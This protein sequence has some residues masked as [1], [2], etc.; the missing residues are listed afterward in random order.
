MAVR[1][2]PLSCSHWRC[3][4]RSAFDTEHV[5]AAKTPGPNTHM[6]SL[7]QLLCLKRNK[8][9]QTNYVARG[10]SA[11]PVLI[12]ET[13]AEPSKKGDLEACCFVWASS[14]CSKTLRH[15][16]YKTGWQWLSMELWQ[17]LLPFFSTVESH[18]KLQLCT[19]LLEIE[20]VLRANSLQGPCCNS[21]H[22]R[23][24][25]VPAFRG[26]PLPEVKQERCH[27]RKS[28]KDFNYQMSRG[29]LD[30]KWLLWAGENAIR[31]DPK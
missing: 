9:L 29:C 10:H 12:F 11:L 2:R 18:L 17:F 1:A 15:R 26:A 14:F 3:F 27:S 31:V 23:R 16:L 4:S 6:L 5:L 24:V 7:A 21:F 13:L 19:K 22:L 30:E 25:S 20:K 28:R 8:Y